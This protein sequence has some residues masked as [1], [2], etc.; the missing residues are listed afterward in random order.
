MS[1]KELLFRQDARKRLLQGI[2]TLTQVV[3]VTLGPRGRN[4]LL[5]AAYG[6]PRVT[7][8]GVTVAE[9]IELPD[10]FRNMGARMVREAAAQT[11]EAAGDGTT[12][13]TVLADALVREGFKCVAAGMNPMDLKRGME[14]AT[15]AAV[16]DIE[17]RSRPVSTDTE[18]AQV[19]TNS[20]NGEQE[21]GRLIAD[22]M[23]KVGKDGV[24][25]VEE[26]RGIETSLEV[27]EGM[28][29]ER[30]YL[31]SYFVTDAG[32]MQAIL[33]RPYIL[34]HEKKLATLQG[35]LPVLEAVVRE[36]RSLLVIAEEVESEALAALVVNRLRGSLKVA[37]VKAPGFGDGRRAWLEDIAALTGGTLVSEETGLKIENVT[38]AML[39]QAMKAV[40][41]KDDATIVGGAG[42]QQDIE[43]RCASLRR[44]IDDAEPGYARERLEERLARLAGGVAVISV[45]GGSESEMKERKDR[46]EDALNA[47]RAAVA[48]G[49]VPGGGVSLLYAARALRRLN[50]ANDDQK[51]GIDIVRRAL[52]AP[53]RRI[54]DN[55]GFEGAVIAGRLLDLNDPDYGFDAQAGEYRDLVAAG[56]VDPTRVVR[57]ALRNAASI[58]GLLVTTEVMIADRVE[59]DQD[60]E[61]YPA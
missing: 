4:V 6:P 8:D 28:R 5:G 48:E 45:G 19:G 35:L 29:F 56:I 54:V 3:G 30:G 36:G 10:R 1:A 50:P 2:D 13:S 17:K 18:I 20:A 59:A 41:G 53:L 57:A 38:L 15:D 12:T 40:I 11:N 52:A 24:I 34:L 27:V 51:A 44:Q 42:A 46:V 37:A 32:R 25:T 23:G 47:T 43:A 60:G 14:R 61:A 33:D 9:E 49:I 31:S 21:I 39:G 55:A 7:K 16:A 22:A 26:A 58:A